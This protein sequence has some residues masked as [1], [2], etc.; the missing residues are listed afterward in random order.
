MTGIGVTD[1]HNEKHELVV[2]V[3]DKTTDERKLYKLS[4]TGLYQLKNVLTVLETVHQLKELKWKI[5][6]RHI[7]QGLLQTKKL[8]GLHGRWELIHEHPYTILDVG[9]NEDGIKQITEQLEHCVFQRL[10]LLIGL[11]NDK[12]LSAVLSLLPKYAHYYFTKAQIPTCT[13]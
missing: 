13:Q 4:L 3:A 2:S 5:E 10:H 9:H 7:E 6:D 8:T 12:D 11:V 1:W